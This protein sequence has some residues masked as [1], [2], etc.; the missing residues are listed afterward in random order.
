MLEL[1]VIFRICQA[2]IPADVSEMKLGHTVLHLALDLGVKLIGALLTGRLE[3]TLPGRNRLKSLEVQ[4]LSDARAYELCRANQV[5]VC[6][7][8]ASPLAQ[9]LQ[10]AQVGREGIV[11]L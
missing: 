7:R 1:K 11:A 4:G 6:E 5:P 10:E 2:L 8:A 3:E 9:N